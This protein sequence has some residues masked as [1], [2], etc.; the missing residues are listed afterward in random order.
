MKRTLL[1]LLA[2]CIALSVS[3]GSTIAYL[4]DSDGDVNVM[5][6][7]RVDIELIE[8]ERNVA[9]TLVPFQ[10]DKPIIPGVYPQ[11]MQFGDETDFWPE[12]VHNA[13]DKIVSITNTGNSDAY[14]RLL[15][16]FEVTEAQDF[17]NRKFT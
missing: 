16:A 7:G 5:T 3:I 14:V 13:V 11:E 10:D 2:V 8:Q 12:T 15:F 6:L 17:F 9:G 1:K 4:T